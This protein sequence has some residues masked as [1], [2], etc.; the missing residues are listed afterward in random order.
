MHNYG[1]KTRMVALTN[2]FFVTAFHYCGNDIEN[3]KMLL[4]HNLDEFINIKEK[5]N[6]PETRD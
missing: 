6:A 3:L 2:A 5:I 4:D 1:F